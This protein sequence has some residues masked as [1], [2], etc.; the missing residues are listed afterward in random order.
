MIA[1]ELTDIGQGM[2]LLDWKI[3]DSVSLTNWLILS[4]SVCCL[5]CLNISVDP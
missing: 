1:V 5:S 2:H 4:Y 3:T